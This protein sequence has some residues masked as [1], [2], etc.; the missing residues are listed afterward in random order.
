N[1]AFTDLQFTATVPPD[2]VTGPITIETPHGNFTS[3][4]SF[5]V[6][7]RPPISIQALA[8]N[9]LELSWPVTVGFSPQRSDSLGITAS[10]AAIT[11]LSSRTT[12]G[13][14]Y[15]TVTNAGPNRFFRLLR[16]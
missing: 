14:R 1:A 7:T 6:L 8:G 15:V 3:T 12:N 5:T 11:I 2:A 9:L 10:W 16:P 13:I 4:N